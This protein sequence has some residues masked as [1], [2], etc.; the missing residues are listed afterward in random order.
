VEYLEG[1]LRY[2]RN[3]WRFEPAPEGG[4]LLH[5]S[6]DFEFRSRV[7]EAIAGAVFGDAVRRMVA[8]FET[9]A[10]RLYGAASPGISSS[11]AQSTA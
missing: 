3:E 10:A 5:F 8:A 6:V 4:V 1:P 9:R 2:L 7:F 11:S